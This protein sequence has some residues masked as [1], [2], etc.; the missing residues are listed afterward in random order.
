MKFGGTSVESASAIQRV[1]EIVRSR[2]KQDPVVVV[3]AMAKVTDQLVAMGQKAAEGDCEGALELLPA[4]RE[5][6]LT[7]ARELLSSANFPKTA[8][9]LEDTF[10]QLE[11]F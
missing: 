4:L 7:A 3:S 1:A 9:K 11:D 8:A 10:K 2:R 6:H 5:R